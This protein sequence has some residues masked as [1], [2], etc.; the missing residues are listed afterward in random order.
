MKV[1]EG[2]EEDVETSREK[3][4]SSK[5]TSTA[6][7]HDITNFIKTYN[8]ESTIGNLDGSLGGS[9]LKSTSTKMEQWIIVAHKLAEHLQTEQ[10]RYNRL[11]R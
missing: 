1:T 4:I 5:L 7:S 2:N 8:L 9:I 10:D 3:T 6:S 11:E